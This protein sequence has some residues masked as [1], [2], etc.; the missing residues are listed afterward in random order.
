[1]FVVELGS[2]LVHI[3]GSTTHPDEAFMRQVARTLTMADACHGRILICDRDGKWSESAR[4]WLRE[5]GIRVVRTPYQAPNANA[6]WAA[7]L[8]HSGGVIALA[9]LVETWDNSGWLAAFVRVF[10]H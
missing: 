2:R 8:L 7:Q 5:A 3:I 6:G 4:A 10:V 1:M 9:A